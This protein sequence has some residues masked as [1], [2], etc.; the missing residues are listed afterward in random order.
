MPEAFPESKLQIATELLNEG[1]RYASSRLSPSQRGNAFP[2]LQPNLR[3]F[4]H[5]FERGGPRNP[6][7][8]TG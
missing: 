4:R 7:K 8:M 5:P 6:L 1:T 3:V 2:W